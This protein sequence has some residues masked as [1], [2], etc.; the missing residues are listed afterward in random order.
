MRDCCAALR[1]FPSGRAMRNLAAPALAPIPDELGCRGLPGSA[2]AHPRDGD[3]LPRATSRWGERGADFFK[4]ARLIYSTRRLSRST[5]AN[6][7]HSS[8]FISWS[9][10]MRDTCTPS[11]STATKSQPSRK[12]PWPRNILLAH[13]TRHN[14]YPNT[15]S[16]TFPR[17]Y[18]TLY[19]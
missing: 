18:S 8:N 6:F 2:E 7:R 9:S 4:S 14:H 17:F 12:R 15:G 16:R 13:L 3:S 19:A 10:L 1:L 5:S 11:P